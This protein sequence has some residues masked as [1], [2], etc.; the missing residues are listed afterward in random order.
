[1]SVKSPVRYTTDGSGNITGFSEFQSADFIAIAD[2][3]TGA[4][5]ASAAR[6]ALGLA[7][8]SDVQ[9]YDAELAALS[10]LTPSD[11]NFIVGNGSTFITESG[12]TARDSM[13]LGTSNAVEFNSVLTAGLTVSGASIVLE[14]AT[15]DAYETTL[16]VTDPTADRT[17]TFPNATGTVALTSDITAIDV[18]IAGD[19][20]TGSVTDAQTLTIAG[21]SNEI[22]TSASNQTLTIGLP[23][24]VTI[25]NNLTV[26]GNL[27][28]SGTTTTVDSNTVNI[29]DSI[30]TLNSDETGSPS[31]DGGF[32]IE[33]GSSTNK[34]LIWDESEDKWSVG[35]ETFVAGTFEGALTGNVTGNVTGSSGST[36][37]NAATATALATGRTIG[38][39]GD[40]V[41]TSASFDGS[42]NVTGT[43][44]IQAGSVDF[45]M[46]ADTIDEDNMSSDSATKIPTQQSVKAYV[47]AQI[48]TEDTI[49]ELNDTNISSPAAGHLLIYDNTASVWD[50]ATLTA[51]TNVSIT[52]A[53]G[54]ITITS[55]D[56]NT[57]LSTE[58][59]Q[60][61]VGAMFS[62]NTET[63]ISATYQDGDGTIDLVADLLT[64]EAVE[65]YVNGLIVGGTNVTATYDDAAGTLTIDATDTNTQLTQ[66]QVEDYVGGMVSGTQTFITVAYDDTG[67]DLTYVVPVK[68]EDNMA[69]DSATHLATQQSIKAY[70][71]SQIATED[72]LAE[73]GDVNLTSVADASLLFYDTGTSKWI[74]NVVS[75]DIT[76]ADTGVA[77]IAA[78][79]VDNAMLAGSIA[80][81][82]LSNSSITVS[83]GSNSTATALG[84][85]ITFS[86]TSNEVEVAES[87]GTIT[88]G[89]PN[90][91]TIAGDLTVS[92]TTTTV[93]STTVTINDPLVRYAD[94]NSG[95]SVD[96]GWYGKYVQSSTTKYAGLVWDASASDKFRLWSGNQAE[97]TTTVNVSGTGHTTGTLIAN[98]EGNVT[99]NVTGNA[100][101]ATALA[102]A[103]TIHGVSFDGSANIDLSEVI[104]DTVG[105]MFGSN[106]ETRITV[107]YEDGDGTID[108]V[109]DNDLSNYDN[110]SSGF[111]TATL[112]QEQVEDYVGGMLDG[113][114][115]FITVAYDDTDG[116]IDFTVPVKDED[117]MASDSA[118]HL[119]TQ[120]SI[121]A[122]V[123]SQSANTEEIQDIVGAM[124]AGNTESNITVT[125]D[126]TNGKLDFSVTG[127]GTVEQAFKTI[128][129]SGQDDVVADAAADTLTFA[130]G[131]NITLTTNASNDTITIAS[132]DTT[133][134]TE[135]VQDIVGGMFSS[136][137]ETG[138]TVTYEDGDGT[139]DLV[140]GTLNQDTTG[141]AATATAL[142]TART[143]HG[144]S[145][146]GSANIDLSEVI[147]DTVGA[148]FSSNTE[149]NISVT[150]D[151]SDGTIDLVSTDTQLTTEAVQDIVGAM[152]TGNTETNITVTYEDSDGTID[153]VATG[154][155]TEQIQDIVGAMFTSNTE[156]NITATYE[157]SD[158][159]I[160]LVADLLTEEA[161]EDY[162]NGLIVAGA[163]ITK[164]YDDAAGTLTIA[165]TGGAANAFST[166]AVS[167]QSNVVADAATDTLTLVA[168][169]G[170]TLTTDASADSITFTSAGG[171]GTMPFTEYDGSTD[172]IVLSSTATAGSL[173]VT[174]SGGSSDPLLMLMLIT[175]QK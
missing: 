80:N 108:L 42:G 109:V 102:S 104:Q 15:A 141:N 28:V 147:Q 116:N 13:G 171:G 110:S 34:S 71:D 74:D 90:N 136:N 96:F 163:N 17:I 173:P 67:G 26:T 139:I 165:A 129:V 27:T 153:L 37:G 30:L 72:T 85:T 86:G 154:N 146:D 170:M 137:T 32:E 125:Y 92:G 89:L 175:I 151:D 97:P 55:T 8:G 65:D 76:I 75:G 14:G 164:T 134:T 44:T 52:N 43:A 169:T 45:A 18:D 162:V 36:T 29:G 140:V 133:L 143:I 6:T 79:A 82:K 93:D 49:A 47:D 11:S 132:A 2:G 51:G 142:E 135:A 100:D 40:V 120:Q 106:T 166:L 62:S 16:A 91:V 35:S 167:G 172:D 128:S 12:A 122:Y 115:T 60:D 61:I 113:D 105:A 81:A 70:V 99:G 150:Y 117:N 174:L 145:F 50:N 57:Q 119:A 39:T 73:M 156:T 121:K 24:N 131:S 20:G 5:T 152:F 138:I 33:R 84:G 107:S 7:I 23:N 78:G 127:G 144:V 53:D 66:E 130:A 118:S 159:T 3:G 114:E 77:T 112:T 9:A 68:D 22:E 160:D 98:I 87:G 124:V 158:G 161:V 10:G 25:G 155:T 157:D 103:R 83:D 148:M 64:E 19:S 88:I 101:T 95:N 56:T 94:N 48:A 58:E 41:W 63:N 4:V 111:I 21:T 38:M 123:D 1:M 31:Q 126:D 69:S 54:A 168:G 59:V 46:I 149:T